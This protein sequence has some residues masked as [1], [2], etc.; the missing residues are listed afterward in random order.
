MITQEMLQAEIAELTSEVHRR[1]SA[2]RGLFVEVAGVKAEIQLL[3]N[4]LDL[5]EKTSPPTAWASAIVL[6]FAAADDD[7]LCAFCAVIWSGPKE[8]PS[9]IKVLLKAGWRSLLPDWIRDY[10]I[11]LSMEWKQLLENQPATLLSMISELSVGPLRTMQE[12]RVRENTV[13]DLVRESLGEVEPLPSLSI[14]K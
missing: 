3:Q 12:R 2:L 6:G 4:L 10:F 5:R 8:Q 14:I 13:T 1:L 11:E 7:E 9:E